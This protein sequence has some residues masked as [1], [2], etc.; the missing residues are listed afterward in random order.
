LQGEVTDD[1]L[2]FVFVGGGP[3]GVE[4]VADSHDLIFDVLKGA[5]PDIDLERVCLVLV[6]SGD[7]ILKR[8][9]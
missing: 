1:L 9:V 8:L 4:A 6:N 2:T 3:T 5:Y 7:H